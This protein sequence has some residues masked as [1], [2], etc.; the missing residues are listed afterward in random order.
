MT[1]WISSKINA[2]HRTSVLNQLKEA[3][4]QDVLR[5]LT[6][7]YRVPDLHRTAKRTLQIRGHEENRKNISEVSD[8]N[9]GNLLKLLHQRCKDIPWLKEKLQSQLNIHTQWSSPSIQRELHEILSSFVVERI[10]HDVLLS[11]NVSLI[12]DETS[13]ISGI[14]Q[15]SMCSRYVCQM[16]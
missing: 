1:K 16:K 11:K 9:R 4:Q 8:T 7:Y 14:E 12:M 2:K 13:D 15:V 10:S 5:I 6:Y 3:H